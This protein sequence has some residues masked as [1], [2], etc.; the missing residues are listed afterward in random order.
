MDPV[1]E[2]PGPAAQAAQVAQAPAA[3]EVELA[4]WNSVKDTTLPAELEAYLAIY[5]NGVFAPLARI[6]L[7][8]L[9]GT[10]NAEAAAQAA[11]EQEAQA[12]KQDWPRARLAFSQG[13]FVIADFEIGTIQNMHLD[14][15]RLTGPAQSAFISHYRVRD[16]QIWVDGIDDIRVAVE[17][18]NS[19]YSFNFSPSD[20]ERRNNG[21]GRAY[22]G[23]AVID[24]WY[25]GFL[26]QDFDND[27]E[28]IYGEVCIGAQA[29]AAQK[30]VLAGDVREM[31]DG[32]RRP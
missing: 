23:F 30:S 15:Y 7:E 5:P 6:R 24:S 31:V 28:R 29:S 10:P 2:T 3:T 25:C 16:G 19:T 22:L 17:I 1:V 27:T 20:I 4:V 32:I 8:A 11:R 14:N 12:G 18:L 9:R 26:V 13:K 21:Y